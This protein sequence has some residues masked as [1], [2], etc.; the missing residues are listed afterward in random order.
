MCEVKINRDLSEENRLQSIVLHEKDGAY[1]LYKGNGDDACL[2]VTEHGNSD[3]ILM[4]ITKDLWNK[5]FDYD[6][7]VMENGK[8]VGI[9]VGDKESI[10]NLVDKVFKKSGISCDWGYVAGRG[11]IKANPK[12]VSALSYIF[13]D[14]FENEEIQGISQILIYIGG[15]DSELGEYHYSVE[16]GV[17]NMRNYLL[18]DIKTDKVLS[19][20]SFKGTNDKIKEATE[21]FKSKKHFGKFR[22]WITDENCNEKEKIIEI[23]ED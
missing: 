12:D 8:T 4:V 3:K 18:Q 17:D 16:W 6:A 23:L 20:K 13:R 22:L 1:D 2:Y 15:M 21:F 7:F 14:T 9:V 11:V 5:I 10:Q 19:F